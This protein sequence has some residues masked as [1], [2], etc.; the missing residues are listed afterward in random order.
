MEVYKQIEMQFG[1][2]NSS[3]NAQDYMRNVLK[4]K[5]QYAD[6]VL[7]FS[8]WRTLSDNFTLLKASGE[9]CLF[10]GCFKQCI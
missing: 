5:S 1:K 10:T 4:D 8:K 7:K 3:V 9:E 6:N 2:Y